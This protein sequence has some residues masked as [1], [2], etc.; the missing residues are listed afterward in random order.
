MDIDKNETPIRFLPDLRDDVVGL[1]DR[2][3]WQLAHRSHLIYGTELIPPL[4]AD[5]Y[6]PA[7]SSNLKR[8]HDFVAT[9][10][11]RF[12]NHDISDCKAY[13]LRDDDHVEI[14][15]L[16]KEEIKY[17]PLRIVPVLSQ[18]RAADKWSAVKAQ[19]D[20]IDIT[21]VVVALLKSLEDRDVDIV[22][23]FYG[24]Q[25]AERKSAAQ[26]AGNLGLSRARIYQIVRRIESDLSR[27]LQR[28][29]GASRKPG[30]YRNNF[31]HITDLLSR[32]SMPEAVLLGWVQELGCACFNTGVSIAS[33]LDYI[34]LRY[35]NEF[36]FLRKIFP[37][38]RS[39]TDFCRYLERAAE[40]YIVPD[41]A[42]PDAV[43]ACFFTEA[44]RNEIRNLDVANLPFPDHVT[45][46]L[47]A[48]GFQKGEQILNVNAADLHQNPH[49]TH[50]AFATIFV[51]S[52][53][54]GKNPEQKHPKSPT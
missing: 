5:P 45:E 19:I 44:Q 37:P 22:C 47:R 31:H 23:G 43:F 24:L 25:G 29:G 8:V 3:A 2:L 42:D 41:A 11:F 6:A 52:G 1:P 13:L 50:K 48:A 33:I 16:Y 28:Y 27:L 30:H 15:D 53:R 12:P 51:W 35:P 40:K 46:S 34:E 26:L 32:R 18:Q 14:S 21:S 36:V 39:Y 54:L 20:G 9:T 49:I 38:F 7:Q 10:R 17:R 4:A